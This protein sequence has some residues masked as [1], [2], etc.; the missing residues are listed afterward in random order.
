MLAKEINKLIKELRETN[1]SIFIVEE[2]VNVS[3]ICDEADLAD[4]YFSDLSLMITLYDCIT[5][6]KKKEYAK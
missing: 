1:K 4:A 6:K 5:D 3:T 2:K